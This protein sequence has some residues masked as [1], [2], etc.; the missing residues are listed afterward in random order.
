MILSKIKHA[1]RMGYRAC[2]PVNSP[3]FMVLGAQKSGSSLLHYYLNRHPGMTGSYPKELHYFDQGIHAGKTLQS[4]HRHFRGRRTALHFETSPSY[5]YTP[6]TAALI[7]AHYPDIKLIVSFRDPVRRAYSAW[8]HYR[9]VFESGPSRASKRP[10][11]SR[12]SSRQA[13]VGRPGNRLREKFVTGREVFPSFRECID[14]ELEMMAHD[15]GYEPALLR[16]GLYL[17]QLENYWRYFDESQIM[18]IGFKDLV[19]D[20]AAVLDRVTAFMGARQFD[21][22]KLD[23]K[24]KNSR[25]YPSSMNEDDRQ[26]LTEFYAEPNRQLFERIGRLNW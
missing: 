12:Q 25:Q 2:L 26:F 1:L 13:G 22:S 4:Y 16:R 15:E 5:I 17:Q 10:L 14:I 8:N 3:D 7:H 18:I 23:Y 11:F 21:W 24:P 20:T 19:T 9:Q 6:D